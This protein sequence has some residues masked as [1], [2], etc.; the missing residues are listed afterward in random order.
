MSVNDSPK[1][2]QV[3]NL[4][5]STGDVKFYTL[6]TI[7]AATGN[8][9]LAHKVGEGGFGSVYKVLYNVNISSIR[10]LVNM[11]EYMWIMLELQGKLENGQEI[12][13]K[14]LSHTSGQGIEEF[15]NEVTLIARLQHRN[16]VRLFGYCIQKDEKMLIYEYLPNKGLDC[17]LFGMTQ[18][19]S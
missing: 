7:I 8:F 16:L 19:H 12:A 1:G 11:H 2:D 17:F 6:S 3:E 14:R 4:E 15:R 10:F 5:T 18:L 9:S 13:V